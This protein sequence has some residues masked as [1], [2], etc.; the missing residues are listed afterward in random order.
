MRICFVNTTDLIGGAERCSFDL[1]RGLRGWGHQSTL[2]VGRRL[3]DDPDVLPCVYP[4]WDWMPRAALHQHAGLTDTTLLTPIRVSMLHPAFRAAEVVN[5]HNMH[6]AFWNFWTVPLLSRRCPVVLTLHDEWLYTGD[7]AYT[8]DCERWREACGRCPQMTW[9]IRPDLGGRDST[10]LNLWLKR[11]AMRRT[12]ASRAAVVSPSKWLANRASQSELGRFPMHVIPNGVRLDEFRQLPRAEARA[13]LGLDGGGLYFLFLATNLDDPRKGLPLLE[14]M[15]T[16][17]GLPSGA[18]LL[19][20][21]GRAGEIAARFP[22]L[23]IRAL[24]Y[25]EGSEQL[26][27]CYSAADATL[28]LSSADNLPYAAIEATACGCPLIALQIGGVGEVVENDVNGIL[29]PP[30]AGAEQLADAM[31]LFASLSEERRAEFGAAGRRLALREFGYETFLS[32]YEELFR[33]MTER[34]RT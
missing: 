4:F 13:R 26:A 31:A 34:G 33:H 7:C 10:R 5:I 27:N 2:F 22:A 8:Y 14:R 19:L 29:L 9:K 6:G 20:A 15:L 11:A 16:R 17:H 28:M 18:T 3:S 12:L 32:R 1:H 25:L 24:G 21:G 30:D 23:P